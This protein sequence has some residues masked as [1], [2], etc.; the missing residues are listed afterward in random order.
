[1]AKKFH[2]SVFDRRNQSTLFAQSWSK[3]QEEADD[4]SKKDGTKEKRR[5]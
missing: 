2:N 4:A 3:I 1:M 5:K